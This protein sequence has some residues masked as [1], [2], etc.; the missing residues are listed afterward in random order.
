M[1]P[2]SASLWVEI[3]NTLKRTGRLAEAIDFYRQALAISPENPD[4]HYNLGSAL[5][6]LGDL[7]AAAAARSER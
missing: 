3:G 7:G 2:N 4:T 5:Q 1:T 6:D